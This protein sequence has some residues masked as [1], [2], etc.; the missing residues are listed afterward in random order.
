[1]KTSPADRL[2]LSLFPGQPTAR[3]YHSVVEL[4]G[5]RRSNALAAQRVAVGFVLVNRDHSYPVCKNGTLV[6]VDLL[7]SAS[8]DDGR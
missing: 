1:M 3:V 4:L 5:T 7:R 8:T 6:V 2:P